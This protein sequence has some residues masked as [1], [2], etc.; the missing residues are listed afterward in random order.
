MKTLGNAI[1]S[2]SYGSQVSEVTLG[3]TDTTR[4]SGI[5]ANRMRAWRKVGYF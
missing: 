4:R 1:K 5:D 2:D 3:V